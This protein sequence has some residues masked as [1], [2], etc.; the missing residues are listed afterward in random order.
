MPISWGLSEPVANG[1]ETGRAIKQMGVF[2][3][4]CGVVD[5]GAGERLKDKIRVA[6]KA[7][8]WL[9]L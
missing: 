1:D 5:L 6:Q 8:G 2:D 9:F 4:S 3:K 7:R